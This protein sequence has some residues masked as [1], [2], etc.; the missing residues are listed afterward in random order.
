MDRGRAG[1][2]PGATPT[3]CFT[4]DTGAH[5]WLSG[6][7]AIFPERAYQP[8]FLHGNAVGPAFPRQRL[9]GAFALRHCPFGGHHTHVCG[10]ALPTRRTGRGYPGQRLG[11]SGIAC[12]RVCAE[13]NSV[14]KPGRSLNTNP[15]N[16]PRWCV[17]TLLRRYVNILNH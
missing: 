12:R 3:T 16:T 5:C 15:T 6:W 1:E 4:G 2:S 13:W 14:N 10:G 8:G 7:W 17:V 9:G 11:A